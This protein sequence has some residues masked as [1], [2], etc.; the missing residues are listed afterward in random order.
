MLLACV[1]TTEL[2]S[3]KLL[4]KVLK[5]EEIPGIAAVVVRR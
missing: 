1:L 3:V 5:P 4:V 2:N